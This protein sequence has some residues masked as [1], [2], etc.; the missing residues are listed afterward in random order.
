MFLF[1]NP[2]KHQKTFGFLLFFRGHKV[3]T[4]TRIG[5]MYVNETLERCFTFEKGFHNSRLQILVQSQQ[6]R[7]ESNSHGPFHID[8]ILT[9]KIFLL[10]E[11][12]DPV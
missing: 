3:E 9:L 8:F 6:Q 2:R 7:H 4:F 11:M 1:Y 12:I 5:L 10:T